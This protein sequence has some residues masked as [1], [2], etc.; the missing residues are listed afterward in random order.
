MYDYCLDAPINLVDP[1]G[2]KPKEAEEDNGFWDT[3]GESLAPSVDPQPDPRLKKAGPDSAERPLRPDDVD[4]AALQRKWDNRTSAT[5]WGLSPDA[6]K[7][8]A[9]SDV[10][11]PGLETWGKTMK[12]GMSASGAI[13]EELGKDGAEIADAPRGILKSF[14]ITE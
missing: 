2:L 14:W 3:V 4:R 11:R 10:M 6:D 12:N 1:E 13:V 7:G 5:V 8:E 9:V